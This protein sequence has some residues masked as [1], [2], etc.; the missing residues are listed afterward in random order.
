MSL[1]LGPRITFGGRSHLPL[2]HDDLPFMVWLSLSDGPVGC[3]PGWRIYL[4][5]VGWGILTSN[6]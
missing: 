6:I 2:M 3:I 5:P 4:D 1:A